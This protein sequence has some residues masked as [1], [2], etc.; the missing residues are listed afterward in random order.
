VTRELLA[1][2]VAGAGLVDLPGRGPTSSA[3]DKRP[4]EGR[5]AVRRLGLDGDTQVN[6]KFHGGEGQA[7]YAYAQEDADHWSAELGR[8][9][10]PG[11]FGENL[12]T[13]GLDLTGAVIGERWRVGTALL[14]VTAP[15]TP[16]A[17]FQAHW[18]V[19]QLIKRFTAHGASGAY[20]RVIDAGDVGAGDRI[21]LVAR[22]DHGITLGL[23]FRAFTTEK[24]R[25]AEL[26]PVLDV[27]PGRDRPKVTAAVDARAAAT[28]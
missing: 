8:E 27:L 7:V 25:L 13:A 6:K 18:G 14:E 12:R 19:P 16:C 2:C 5:V 4:V 11:R 21:E 24:H 20:L 22:P 17:K 1:V 3:I 28:A 15:R 10:P 23:A 9:L 26:A